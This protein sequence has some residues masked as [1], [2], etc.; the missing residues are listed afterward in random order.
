M[1]CVCVRVCVWMGGSKGNGL[2]G[3]LGCASNVMYYSHSSIWR[4]QVIISIKTGLHKTPPQHT[5]L[6]TQHTHTHTHRDFTELPPATT[7][8]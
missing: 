7:P 3:V 8:G 6:H 4:K 1:L 5:Y 2:M